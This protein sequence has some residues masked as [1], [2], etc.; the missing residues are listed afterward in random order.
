MTD[1]NRF[2]EEYTRLEGILRE[3]NTLVKDYEETLNDEKMGKLRFCR[4]VRNFI[5]HNESGKKFATV[6]DEMIK[7]LQELCYDLSEGCKP[8]KK[9]MTLINKGFTEKS[10]I[11]ELAKALTKKTPLSSGE[12]PIF[13]KG[14]YEGCLTTEVLT[15]ILANESNVKPTSKISLY[16][17]Y[18]TNKKPKIVS[19]H[20]Q[21]SNVMGFALVKDSKGCVTSYI[22]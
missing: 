6:S 3:K 17:N 7:F 16:L 12:I 21:I 22:N 1:F 14:N 18:L 13:T 5:A 15:K 2:M 9:K 11:S 8:V 10:T 19:E 20:E 4:T